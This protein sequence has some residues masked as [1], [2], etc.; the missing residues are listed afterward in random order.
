MCLNAQLVGMLEGANDNRKTLTYI[1]I[2]CTAIYPLAWYNPSPE[3]RS[4]EP[5][6]RNRKSE[7]RQPLPELYPETLNSKTLSPQ[8]RDHAARMVEPNPE[9]STPHRLLGSQG[10]AALRL[11]SQPWPSTLKLLHIR[12]LDIERK[13]REGRETETET[14]A[15]IDT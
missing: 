2:A 9:P 1:T 8:P 11:S 14:K 6:T 13:E 10:T 3:I 5:R 12:E 15:E 4:P 7:T